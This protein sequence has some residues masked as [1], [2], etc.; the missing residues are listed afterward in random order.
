MISEHTTDYTVIEEITWNIDAND[1]TYPTVT[2][3][4]NDNII[5]KDILF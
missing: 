5:T 4:A 1:I 2:K 3:D